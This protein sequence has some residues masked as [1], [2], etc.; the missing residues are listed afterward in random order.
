[1]IKIKRNIVYNQMEGLF[2]FNFECELIGKAIKWYQTTGYS[3]K[4]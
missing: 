3:Y 2:R 1:M 4:M